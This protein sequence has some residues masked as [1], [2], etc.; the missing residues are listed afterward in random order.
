MHPVGHLSTTSFWLAFDVVAT[1][2]LGA[3]PYAAAV[4]WRVGYSSLP[5]ALWQLVTFQI[6]MTVNDTLA[7][8]T[9]VVY[10][11][12]M[13]PF[14]YATFFTSFWVWLF[15]VTGPTVRAMEGLLSGFTRLRGI[16]DV[17]EKPGRSL[18]LAAVILVTA[19]YALAVP[20]LLLLR[21]AG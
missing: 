15:A 11:M 12:P 21:P 17:E 14:F 4:L 3:L 8:G 19:L 5:K 9:A 18:G 6:T 10:A 7:D 1:A 16:L 20:V 2:I 13:S